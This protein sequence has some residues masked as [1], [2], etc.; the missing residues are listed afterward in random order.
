MFHSIKKRK[1]NGAKTVWAL[2]KSIRET[3]RAIVAT[4]LIIGLQFFILVFSEFVP[5]LQF[6]VLALTGVIAALIF[7]LFFLPSL[8]VLLYKD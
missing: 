1:E 3:G 6:G 8:L 4:T 5:I 2:A 7:D